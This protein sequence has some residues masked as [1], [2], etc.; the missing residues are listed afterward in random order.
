MELAPIFKK[1]YWSLAFAGLLYVLAIFSL[2]YPAIQRAALYAH[3]INP[4]KFYDN[5]NDVESYGFTKSQAQPFNIQTPD[6]ETLYAWHILPPHLDHEHEAELRRN[7]ASGV[8]KDFTKTTSFKLL[9]QDPNARVV[10]NLH[11][12]AAHLGTGYRPSVYRNFLSL[13]TPSRP[14][15]V[16][17]FDY[18][19]FGYST[20]SPTEEGLITDAMT[21]VDYLTAPPLSI[22]PSRIVVIGQSLGTAVA[23]GLLERYSSETDSKQTARTPFAGVVLYGSFTNLPE[24]LRSYSVMGIFPPIL[25]PLI[26][27]PWAQKYV[28]ENIV[29]MWNT[30]GRL[31]ALTG[32]SNADTK[33]SRESYALDL[34]IMHAADDFDIPWP[35]GRGVW[36]SATGGVKAAELGS[37]VSNHTSED[38]V[39]Q[40]TVWERHDGPKKALKRVRWE[41]V[42][43]GGHNVIACYSDAAI[44]VLRLLNKENLV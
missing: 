2:T 4:S 12:N 17:T 25:S 16:I 42:R 8:A 1:A 36:N 21:V 38:G 20:G 39:T 33:H 6:N 35:L 41:R 34:T 5:P 3:K 10:L 31:A 19:G 14:V 24:L 40:S 11:G 32:V 27:Y 43:Y 26:G 23:V 29:D 22:S 9:S 13:S 7:H 15:H 28:T 44:A 37:F 18:R 30:S